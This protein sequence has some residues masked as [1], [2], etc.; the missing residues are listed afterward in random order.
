MAKQTLDNGATF[1]TQ[2]A[3][4]N[5]NFSELYSSAET[6][7]QDIQAIAESQNLQGTQIQV[8]GEAIDNLIEAQTNQGDAITQLTEAFA[9]IFENGKIK[10]DLIPIFFSPSYFQGDGETEGD[11]I[12]PIG[13]Q[14]PP[15]LA[16]PSISIGTTTADAITINWTSVPNATGYV[17]EMPSNNG[18]NS[19]DVIY[20]GNLITFNKSGL[21]PVTLY[22]FR[23]K[24]IGTGYSDSPYAYASQTTLDELQNVTAYETI[25]Q[26]SVNS[27]NQTVDSVASGYAGTDSGRY[28][29]IGYAGEVRMTLDAVFTGALG[30]DVGDGV[31][32]PSQMDFQ[33]NRDNNGTVVCVTGG[34]T[35]ENSGVTVPVSANSIARMLVDASTIKYQYSTNSGTSWTQ[36]GSTK[37]RPGAPLKL[38]TTF[39]SLSQ[40]IH[41]IQEMG[42]QP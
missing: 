22:H 4:I 28:F 34:S 42:L 16:A 17:L 9:A 3:K 14:T 29:P 8:Q 19:V 36:I 7:G 39:Y 31:A 23:V 37:T 21:D 20:S 33:M 18:F 26:V 35:Y 25:F 32:T 10:R 15:Q 12:I 6:T 30:L 2:R 5:S 11:P 38:K 1:G 24:A 13:I 40:V 27:N 41:N